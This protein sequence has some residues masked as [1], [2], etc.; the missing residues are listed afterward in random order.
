MKPITHELGYYYKY[1]VQLYNPFVSD[2]HNTI[3]LPSLEDNIIK[4]QYQDG[5]YENLYQRPFFY[6]RKAVLSCNP[7][8]ARK[9]TNFVVMAIVSQV[10]KL[11]FY[12]PENKDWI[13]INWERED[14]SY[15]ED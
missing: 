4:Q 3:N 10:S 9:R 8:F 1:D 7:L 13:T 15:F 11:A 12:T 5:G 14:W 6:V 2:K